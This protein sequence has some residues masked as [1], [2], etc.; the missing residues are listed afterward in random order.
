MPILPTTGN[1]GFHEVQEFMFYGECVIRNRLRISEGS[2]DVDFTD[3]SWD[4]VEGK[5]LS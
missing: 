1:G 4:G 3:E 5:E 2:F